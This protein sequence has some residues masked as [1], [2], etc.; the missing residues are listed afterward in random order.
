MSVDDRPTLLALLHVSWE[1]PHRILDACGGAEVHTSKPL[2]GE[3]LPAHDEVAGVVVMGGPMNVDD[4]E[5]FTRRSPTSASG[6]PRRCGARCRCSAS[7]SARSCWRGRSA[8]RCGRGR[9]RRSAS[10]TVDVND[11]NDPILGALAPETPMFH[12]HGDVFDLP[13]GAVAARLLGEDRAPGLP[14]RQRLGRALP[15]RGR[16]RPGRGLDGSAGDGRWRR[17]RRSATRRRRRSPRRPKSSKPRPG[18]R[19]DAGLPRLRR[20]GR[21]APRRRVVAFPNE[22]RDDRRHLSQG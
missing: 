22:T 16:R 21:A 8:P 7:A 18:R 15:S 3:P 14:P 17:S 9:A 2:A 5:R 13:E 11:P 20:A 1:R 10:P 19:T 6:W 12:W 4:L